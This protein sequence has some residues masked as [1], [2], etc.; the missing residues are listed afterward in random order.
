MGKRCVLSG[1]GLS[2]EQNWI[3]SCQNITGLEWFFHPSEYVEIPATLCDTCKHHSCIW[4]SDHTT[5]IPENKKKAFSPLKCSS[6]MKIFF[7][8]EIYSMM[9]FSI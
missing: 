8:S 7:N 2:D 6:I 5:A 9:D 4:K 3:P 1:A